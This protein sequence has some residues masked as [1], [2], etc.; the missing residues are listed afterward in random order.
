MI[1]LQANKFNV[2]SPHGKL[3][4]LLIELI[5]ILSASALRLK[6]YEQVVAKIKFGLIAHNFQY[7][8]YKIGLFKYFTTLLYKSELF[9]NHSLWPALHLIPIRTPT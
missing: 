2:L 4:L 8:I 5:K 1:F 6:S 3:L 9:V 7:H